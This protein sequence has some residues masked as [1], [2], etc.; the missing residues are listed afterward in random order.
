MIMVTLAGTTRCVDMCQPCRH[1]QTLSRRLQVRT[2]EGTLEPSSRMGEVG[3][4]R[5]MAPNLS[6]TYRRFT[7]VRDEGVADQS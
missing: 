3:F 5:D 2:I 4:G 1:G 7:N 6:V